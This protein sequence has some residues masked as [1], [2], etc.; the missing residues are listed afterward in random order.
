MAV[1]VVKFCT[2]N[3]GGHATH[4]MD[5]W[6]KCTDYSNTLLLLLWNWTET[7]SAFAITESVSTSLTGPNEELHNNRKIWMEVNGAS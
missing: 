2:L 6:L 1:S 5:E 3:S 4:F 7:G